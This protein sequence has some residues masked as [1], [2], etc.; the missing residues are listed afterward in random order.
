[1]AKFIIMSCILGYSG[2]KLF[3]RNKCSLNSVKW[4]C[5]SGNL[6]LTV[7]MVLKRIF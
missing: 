4:A 6:L 1:M 2:N 3:G 5:I 7:Y